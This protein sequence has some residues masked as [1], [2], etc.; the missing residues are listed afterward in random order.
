MNIGLV[1]RLDEEVSKWVGG[2]DQDK[3]YFRYKKVFTK[4]KTGHYLTVYKNSISIIFA[5]INLNGDVSISQDGSFTF[6]TSEEIKA[7]A[8]TFKAA[9]VRMS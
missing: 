2:E 7:A 4:E 6:N 8:E 9:I 5:W 3:V 1:S